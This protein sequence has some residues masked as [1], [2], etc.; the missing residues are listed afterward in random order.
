MPSPSQLSEESRHSKTIRMYQLWED[1]QADFDS[2]IAENLPR[3]GSVGSGKILHAIFR[4]EFRDVTGGPKTVKIDL[5]YKAAR[6]L[7]EYLQTRLN[8]PFKMFCAVFRQRNGKPF[9]ENVLSQQP[10]KAKL[11]SKSRR[12]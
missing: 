12:P 8:V 11:R 2:W 9:K 6:G 1:G 10:K 3:L 7:A 5:D 4:A